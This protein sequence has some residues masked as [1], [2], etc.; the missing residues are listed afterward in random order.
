MKDS[1]G[2]RQQK[3]YKG[4]QRK[5]RIRR[6]AECIRMYLGSRH[7][8]GKRNQLRPEPPLPHN[9][10]HLRKRLYRR[11]RLG[12]F[13]RYYLGNNRR[14][15]RIG[16]TREIQPKHQ[17]SVASTSDA[18]RAPARLQ[19]PS[20]PCSSCSSARPRIRSAAHDA[21]SA[22]TTSSPT[23]QASSCGRNLSSPLLPIAIATFLCRR[24]RLVRSRGDPLNHLLN[25]AASI[26]ASHSSAGLINS[27]RVCI[28]SF[29]A[30]GAHRFHGQTSWQ[31]SQPNTC[32]PMGSRSSSA[33]A[34][35]FS[36]V[37]YAMHRDASISRG[38]TS[39]P[40]GQASRQRV[41][42]PHRSAAAC[43]ETP[44]ATGSEVTITPRSSHDP[45][46]WFNT[47]VFLPIQ[48]TPAFTAADRSTRG[49]VS[50]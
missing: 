41:Q 15:R 8:A 40:V 25:S 18:S 38:A 14:H 42:L 46:S 36:I 39:A 27:G 48:P 24:F 32:R 13:R 21:L 50:T 37:R 7:I 30:T 33:I 45:N 22:S 9:R 6:H 28:P 49:P 29:T 19:P 26:P 31:I 10:L 34:P 2:Q 43:N 4:K 3:H 35:F 1:P 11:R 23:L 16:R 17:N 20:L 44:A 5:N 47:Q 12:R